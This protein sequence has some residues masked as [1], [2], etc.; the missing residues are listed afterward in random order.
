MSINATFGS[1]NGEINAV[2]STNRTIEINANSLANQKN[3][4][5]NAVIK[6]PNKLNANTTSLVTSQSQPTIDLI[7]GVNQ[8]FLSGLLD[9]DVRNPVDGEVLTYNANTGK[10]DLMPV[11]APP[12]DGGTF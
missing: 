4:P 5:I 7:N 12:T 11:T 10:F 9:V 3:M 1:S 2:V 8:N 6:F